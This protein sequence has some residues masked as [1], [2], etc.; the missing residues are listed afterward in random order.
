MSKGRSYREPIEPRV[1]TLEQWYQRAQAASGTAL[2]EWDLATDEWEWTPPVALLFGFNPETP[3]RSFAGWEP[4]IFVDDVPKLRAAADAARENGAFYCEFRVRH[5]N[6][7]VRWIA[8]RGEAIAAS[9]GELLRLTGAFY[10]ISDRKELEARLLA[11][12]ETLES[13]VG[14]RVR[15]LAVT[16]AQLEE[17]ER[18]L[19]L[20][21]DAVT[22]YAI[23]M[24]DTAGNVVSWNPGAERI[25]G[26]ASREILGQHFSRFYTHVDRQKGVPRIALATA[27]RIGKYE[28]EGWRIRKDGSTFWAS[29]VINAI[30]DATGDLLGYAKVT[31]DITERMKAQEA[32]KESAEMARDVIASALDAFVQINERGEITE[33]NKQAEAIFGWSREEVLGHELGCVI[34]PPAH[35]ARHHEGLEHFL[36][37]GEG[38]VIGHRLETDGVRRDGK[39]ICV[40]LSIT[41]LRRRDGCVYNGFL[42]DI[43][44]KKAI[45]AQLRQAQKMEAI[46]QLTGGVAHDFNNLLTVIIGNIEHLQRRFPPGHE[47]ERIVAAALRGASRAAILTERLLAFSR[48]QALSPQ[49]ISVNKLV[50][51]MS[52]LLRRTLGETISIE[53]VLAGGLW[54]TFIDAN[55]LENALLNLAV[56]ARDAMPR[57]GRLTIETANCYLDEVYAN[58]HQDVR[59][60]Q[61]VGLFVTD[62]GTGMAAAIVAQAFEPFFTTKSAGEGTGLGLS[63]VYGFVKQSEGHVKLY[64]EIGQ[65]TT[66]KLYL[67]RHHGPGDE[68]D[69]VVQTRKVPRGREEETVLIVEDDPDVREYTSEMVSG[70]GYRTLSAE[71]GPAALR[72]LDDNPDVQL[73]FTDVVLP[74]GMNGRR[75]AQEAVRRRPALKVLFTTGYARNAIV[76]QGRLDPDV[77]VVFKPFT[78]SQLAI[79]IR[80]ALDS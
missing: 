4:A 43:T 76:H 49:V 14:D 9:T 6:G 46:G 60:G 27:E 5:G 77:E 64:S 12:T 75:L 31:R 74:G 30:R 65:G 40:E 37:T 68:T 24:L 70:L 32:I 38:P 52:E 41:A 39:E 56:N 29:V 11:L 54:V 36:R 16:A 61:Y 26:Y 62:T 44:E 33:W 19:R 79:K 35:R 50:A 71:N 73:L 15:Q 1:R 55:Q 17:T 51:G 7:D 80:H 57:G 66:V 13:N 78:Y 63:Q 28:A 58:R 72:M 21:I 67:P 59:P 2:F 48:R 47:L 22:D 23:F 34:I 69:D 8:G 25:T 18:R 53:T 45:E 10:E 20:L 42:R 3:R